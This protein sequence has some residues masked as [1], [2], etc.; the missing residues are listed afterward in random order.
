[1]GDR[2]TGYSVSPR[3]HIID[4]GHFTWVVT[5]YPLSPGGIER[6]PDSRVKRLAG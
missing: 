6:R 3:P 1:M 5:L 4:G 2:W